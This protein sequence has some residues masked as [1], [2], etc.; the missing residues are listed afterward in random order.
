MTTTLD[1]R[2]VLISEAAASTRRRPSMFR[3]A[4]ALIT[5]AA[6]A[7][8]TLAATPGVAR[9]DEVKP[10]GKGIA[11]GA[12]LGAEIVTIPMAL[13]R[14]KS[15]WAYVIG[16]GL[17]AVGGGVA[18]HFIEQASFSNDGRPPTY[19]L[20]GGLA[21]VIPAVILVLN[22]TRYQPAEEPSEDRAPTNGPPADPGRAG[23][24]VVLEGGGSTSQPTAPTTPPPST[25][26]AKPPSTGSSQPPA[27]PMSLLDLHRT[28]GFRMGIP[29]PEVRES[30][31]LAERKNLGVGQ[32]T[33]LRL[34]IFHATF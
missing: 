2:S 17:G 22:A 28:T 4:G 27:L 30:Y 12:L 25:T 13:F 23:G 7:T 6:F 24:S 8:A 15:P 5:A 3:R 1:E 19:M 20:A 33:E 34:P 32:V 31:S 16:G 21:L 10:D 26:P 9:A 11:G 18:G 14:V 29:V